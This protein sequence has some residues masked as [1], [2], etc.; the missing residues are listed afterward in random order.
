MINTGTLY[1]ISAPSGAGKSSLIQAILKMQSN[2]ALTVSISYT[3]R[4]KRPG[5][6]DGEH[7][8]FIDH[9]TFEKMIA[10]NAFLEYAEVYGQYYGTARKTI[11]KSLSAG[12]DVFLDIDW[13]GARQTKAAFPDAKS[14]FIL[15]PSRDELKQRLH[16]RGQDSAEVIAKRMQKATS[17]MSHYNEYDYVIINDS[18]ECTLRELNAILHAERLV[19]AKQEKKYHALIHQLLLE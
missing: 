16:Q 12:I 5:E 19:V 7:Y 8:Y 10:E 15:P 11:E 2:N 4:E 3:T 9:K 17:E 18:F 1:I 13:Q 6:K 14:I